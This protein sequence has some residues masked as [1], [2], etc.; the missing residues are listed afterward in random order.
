MIELEQ[1]PKY[2]AMINRNDWEKLFALLPEIEDTKEIDEKNAGKKHDDS[3]QTVQHS[4]AT[5]IV[6]KTFKVISELSL[7]PIFYWTTWQEEK[8]ILSGKI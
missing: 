1:F 4:S 7:T 5:Q 3:I 8:S 6:N 2:L